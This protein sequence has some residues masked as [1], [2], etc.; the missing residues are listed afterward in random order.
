MADIIDPKKKFNHRWKKDPRF[1]KG[2]DYD[3]PKYSDVPNGLKWALPIHEAISD[4]KE[5]ER[6]QER[7]KAIKRKVETE[8]R[9][10]NLKLV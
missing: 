4:P 7:E 5:V 1:E 6:Q 3:D 9:K 10:K 8:F 2:F